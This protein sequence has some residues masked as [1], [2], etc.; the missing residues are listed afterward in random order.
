MTQKEYEEKQNLL[1]RNLAE[2]EKALSK[3]RKQRATIKIAPR[4]TVPALDAVIADF[5]ERY[6]SDLIKAHRKQYEPEA[7]PGELAFRSWGTEPLDNSRA[8]SD[9]VDRF[10]SQAVK[11]GYRRY[12]GR[13]K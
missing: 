13:K 8:V 1:L 4:A 2:N 7:D 12:N 11:E 5:V 10:E 6:E 9:F 3:V